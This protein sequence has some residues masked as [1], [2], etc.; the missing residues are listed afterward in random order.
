MASSTL[1]FRAGLRRELLSVSARA[2]PLG[3]LV[4]DGAEAKQISSKTLWV[5]GT[6]SGQAMSGWDAVEHLPAASHVSTFCVVRG[7]GENDSPLLERLCATLLSSVDALAEEE[8][9]IL[10]EQAVRLAWL[11]PADHSVHREALRVL[12]LL[13]SGPTGGH[14]R[15]S[16]IRRG[17]VYSIPEVVRN[18]DAADVRPYSSWRGRQPAS[19]PSSLFRPTASQ[20]SFRSSL[21]QSF[22]S[23]I[24]GK[25]LATMKAN[26][27]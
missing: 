16:D 23:S 17:S 7:T 2:E 21:S 18:V 4:P 3:I 14:H 12:L 13:G 6:A 24:H 27:K 20:A 26:G 15:F 25:A 5:A 10:R 22:A 19:E 11:L 8:L 1:F 9:S